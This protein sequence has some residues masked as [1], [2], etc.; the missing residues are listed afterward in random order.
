M[1]KVLF[2]TLGNRD[3]QLPPTAKELSAINDHFDVGNID[4]QGN[5]IIKK[6]DKNFVEHSCALWEKYDFYHTEVLFPM[7][8]KSI[9]IAGNDLSK[10]V[11]I[12]TQQ[13]PMDPQDCHYVAL[14]LEKYLRDRNYDVSY[15]PIQFPPVNLGDL[16][17]F[18]NALFKEYED[19][20]IIFGNSGGTP[21]MRAASHLAA[22]FKNVEFIT[23]QTRKQPEQTW[24][25]RKQESLVLKH[26]IEKMLL[27]Y[28]YSGITIL[29]IQNEQILNLSNYAQRRLLLD[30]EG[31][32]SLEN[33]SGTEEFKLNSEFDVIEL[34][35]EMAESARIKYFQKAYADYLWRL[36]AISDNLFVPDV[37][38]IL[39]GKI[40]YNKKQD[41]P[42]WN[43]LLNK[44]PGLV[45]KLQTAK[46][47]KSP[48]NYSEPNKYAY[49][50]ILKFAVENNG[51][52]L[53]PTL[54]PLFK[55]L[56]ELASLRNSIAHNLKGINKEI[57][58]NKIPKKLIPS[59]FPPIE[60]LNNLICQHF[61]LSPNN[62]GVY[63]EINKKILKILD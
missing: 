29:P 3:L 40:I 53:K 9:D 41:H 24:N 8:Q 2:L 30:F 31:L 46:Y 18:F 33:A 28:D 16:V 26:I 13:T 60:G 51:H 37:E 38:I 50:H 57:I 17:D 12:T 63:T 47:N 34:M 48:L 25:F 61:N 21:D 6:S 11:L 39:G 58:E 15:R 1:K 7:V 56:S 42:E 20:Q 36:F 5:Y 10:I 45:A 43:E 62:I 4:T 32:K 22:I 19:F 14:F 59:G 52:I 49:D 44:I 35:V 23:L 27:N 54:M 55:V